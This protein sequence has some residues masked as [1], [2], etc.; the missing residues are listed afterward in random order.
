MV[1]KQKTKSPRAAKVAARGRRSRS[2]TGKIR[3]ISTRVS[4]AGAVIAGLIAAFAM[5]KPSG[6][7]AAS[8]M[9]VGEPYTPQPYAPMEPTPYQLPVNLP[10]PEYVAPE[11]TPVSLAPIGPQTFPTP[12][13]PSTGPPSIDTDPYMANPPAQSTIDSVMAMY[14]SDNN[15]IIYG[16][17]LGYGAGLQPRFAGAWL[18]E[19]GALPQILPPPGWTHE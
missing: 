1:K 18:R 3:R 9:P 5:S 7:A 17:F 19:H 16:Y 11:P 10:D 4:G 8:P 14:Q 13:I 15:A 12:V 2:S 6:Q